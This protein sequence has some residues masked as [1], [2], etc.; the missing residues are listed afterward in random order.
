MAR[1]ETMGEEAVDKGKMAFCSSSRE[2]YKGSHQGVYSALASESGSVL[3]GGSRQKPI[4][5]W[6]RATA[7]SEICD[8][9]DRAICVRLQVCM[10]ARTHT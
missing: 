5:I 2:F 3:A 9:K 10:H 8:P 1:P 4:R 6:G 7:S